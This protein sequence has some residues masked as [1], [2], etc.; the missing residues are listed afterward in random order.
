MKL[1]FATGNKMKYELMSERLKPLTDIEVVIPKMLDLNIDI[2]EDG[3]TP[4]ENAIKKAKQYYEATHMPVIA[5][6]SGLYIDEFSE[7]EQPG[8]FVKRVN[9]VEGLSDEEVINHY[10]SKLNEHGGKSLAA[11]HTGVCLIDEDGNLHT[12]LIKETKFLLTAEKN[13]KEFASGGCLDCIS[14]DIDINKYFNERTDEDKKKHY[15]E[16]DNIYRD[17]VSKYILKK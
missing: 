2:V 10:I 1:L 7:D 17:L 4:T 12:D 14:Y 11:Y 15:K 8:L 6:D 3:N 13:E 5:E 9:G 16:L